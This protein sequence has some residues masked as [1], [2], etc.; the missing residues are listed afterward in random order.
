M[1]RWQVTISGKG[2]RKASVEKLV[3]KLEEEFGEDASVSCKDATPP[4]SRA[5]RF[6]AAVNSIS[7]GRGEIE[8]L[9]DELQD[10]FDNL[11]EN[12]QNGDKG[13]EIQEGIGNLET[14]ASSLEEAE[15]TDVNFPGMY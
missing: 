5:D 11:P 2:I 15:G 8:C 4:E 1:A 10:W 9:R 13:N 6:A 3:K 14:M 7:D 12:F